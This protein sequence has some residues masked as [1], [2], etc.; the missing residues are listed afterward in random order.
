MTTASFAMP[1]AMTI[2]QRDTLARLWTASAFI[3]ALSSSLIFDAH[4]GLNWL[5][6]ITAASMALLTVARSQGTV[7]SVAP[8]LFLALMMGLTITVASS[9]LLQA[10]SVFAVLV[11]L[12]IAIARAQPDTYA[13]ASLVKLAALPIV[14]FASCVVEAIRRAT[15]TVQALTNDRAVPWIRGLVLTLPIAGLF[16][17]L[18]SSVDP[19][20]DA[21]RQDAERLFSSWHFVPRLVFF[22]VILGLSLGALGTALRPA[23]AVAREPGEARP[24][25]QLG[26]TERLMVLSAIA[27]VFT[28]FLTLQLSYLFGDVARVQGNGMSYAEW[29]R[30]GF[31]ELTV[32]STL[33]GGVIMA[34]ALLAPAVT[35]R[36]RILVVELVVL[37]ETQVLLHSAFRRVLLY[38]DAYGFTTS[39]LYAQAYML[40][41]AASLVLLA[42]ELLRRPNARRLLGRAGA[43]AVIGMAS[44]GVWNHEAWIV[45]QNV[46]REARAGELDMRY[47]ACELS[48]RAVPEVLRAADGEGGTPRELTR[49]AISERFAGRQNAWYEW[50]AG[51][52]RAQ[53]AMSA[54]GIAP[55]SVDSSTGVCGLDWTGKKTERAG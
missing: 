11:L 13:R 2:A 50:N 9:G 4:P 26:E 51:R 28:L 32:V 35:R 38:E 23:R 12:A 48:A 27:G 34:L 54:E 1:T 53:R 30:R 55:R 22:T 21:W 43:L 42:H 6:C 46:A 47:L 52:A 18:L 45:R 49:L 7:R 8:P 10:M 44:V 40:V 3:A 15:E 31:A 19:T 29:A 14:V 16:A 36:R 5:M 37:G 24:L 25:V 17:L 41:V 39:R 20:L 33:C